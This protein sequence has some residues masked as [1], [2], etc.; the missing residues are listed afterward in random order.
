VKKI[1]LSLDV[2]GINGLSLEFITT[3]KQACSFSKDE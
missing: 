3:R 1:S 2:L